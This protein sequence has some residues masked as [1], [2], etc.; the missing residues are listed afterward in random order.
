[1]MR[2][3][4]P[5]LAPMVYG[6]IGMKLRLPGILARLGLLER[7]TLTP[8]G[9][10][11]AEMKR[12]TKAM[13]ADGTRL[14]CLSLHSSTILPRKTN[15]YVKDQTSLSEFVNRID[16]FL[17]AFKTEY[18]GKFVST[19]EARDIAAMA[20]INQPQTPLANRANATSA[21]PTANA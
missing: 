18:H 5:A 20:R 14:F 16:G 19:F 12:L 21:I 15:L 3:I 9:M 1:M 10:T 8:E 11:L 13:I 17:T 7:G 4:G 2:K 6:P